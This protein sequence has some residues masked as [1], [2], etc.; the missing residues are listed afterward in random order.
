MG[1]DIGFIT[2]LYPSESVVVAPMPFDN[3]LTGGDYSG[4]GGESMYTEKP[5]KKACTA[6]GGKMPTF[7][8]L[9]AMFYN[10]NLI[11]LPTTH[12][13]YFASRNSTEKYFLYIT[14][15]HLMKGNSVYGFVRCIER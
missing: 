3:D 9:S 13:Y 10:K 8:E 7:E 14:D 15:G 2:A 4:S 11:S 5:A 6:K 12:P 1:K